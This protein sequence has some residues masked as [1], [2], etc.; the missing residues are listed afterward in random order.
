MGFAADMS[1]RNAERTKTAAKAKS[2]REIFQSDIPPT[3]QDYYS[4]TSQT[5]FS[6]TVLDCNSLTQIQI[7]SLNLSSE[8]V[9]TPT[10]YVVL[11]RTLF[12]PEGGGQLGDQGTL[13]KAKVVDTRI[14][15]GVIYH[16]T[17]CSVEEG[18]ISGQIDWERRRQLMLSLIHI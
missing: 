4:D 7:E 2:K 15:N 10:H 18:G 17:N 3:Q 1:A 9:V 8:V 12:Y 11:D 5:E 16:L 13:G 14:E 6:A